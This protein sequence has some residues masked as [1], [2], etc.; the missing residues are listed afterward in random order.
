MIKV[1]IVIVGGGPVGVSF[2]CA[3]KDQGFRIALIEK[4]L[5]SHR[6]TSSHAL[7]LDTL[8]NAKALALSYSS[9][10]CL[11]TLEVF[12]SEDESNTLQPILEVRVSREGQF[13]VTK[14]SARVH[15]LP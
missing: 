4:N 2:A 11:K 1:D 7:S 14:L 9:V 6:A 10:N 12:S 5:P 15:H 3:L 8:L 13:G